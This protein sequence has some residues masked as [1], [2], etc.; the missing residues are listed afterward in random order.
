MDKVVK[1]GDKYYTVKTVAIGG[2]KVEVT[3]EVGPDN[4]HPAV[5]LG[6]VPSE[7]YLTADCPN[8]GGEMHLKLQLTMS[9]YPTKVPRE[10]SYSEGLFRWE[11]GTTEPPLIRFMYYECECGTVYPYAESRESLVNTLETIKAYYERAATG[12]V[13][14]DDRL[15]EIAKKMLEVLNS[16]DIREEGS[17]EAV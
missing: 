4:P 3:K 11:R 5:R 2:K 1:A 6:L 10:L 9:R 17:H 13:P 7:E 14:T 16:E 15:Y 12:G 8:C